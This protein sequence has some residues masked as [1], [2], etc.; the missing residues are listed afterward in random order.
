MKKRQEKMFAK[1]IK[2]PNCHKIFLSAGNGNLDIRIVSLYAE[3]KSF[4]DIE[5]IL[6]SEGIEIS[7]ATIS[8]RIHKIAME[9]LMAEGL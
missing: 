4:R 2:C 3:G 9:K 8:R 5:T 1:S 7:F 6:R